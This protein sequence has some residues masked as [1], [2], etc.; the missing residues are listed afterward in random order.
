MINSYFKICHILNYDD[1]KK[2]YIFILSTDQNK[3]YL[4]HLEYMYKNIFNNYNN[5]FKFYKNENNLRTYT[6]L[7]IKKIFNMNKYHGFCIKD[8]KLKN[9]DVIIFKNR[10]KEFRLYDL[11]KHFYI[12]INRSGYFLN[13]N[14][15]KL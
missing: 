5:L 14:D 2:V 8:I 15:I 10:S 9:K 11:I 13:I 12:L 4:L 7:D 1:R 6:R 3:E